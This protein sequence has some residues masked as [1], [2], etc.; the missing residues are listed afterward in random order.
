MSHQATIFKISTHGLQFPNQQ[1]TNSFACISSPPPLK[2]CRIPRNSRQGIT[3]N[4]TITLRD[5]LLLS[6][7]KLLH[8]QERTIHTV[9]MHF[10]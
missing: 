4:T 7:S 8:C 6:S 2:C 5:V 9:E 10:Q 1:T 3:F